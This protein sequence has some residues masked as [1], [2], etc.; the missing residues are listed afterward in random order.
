MPA[1]RSSKSSTLSPSSQLP[2]PLMSSI[3]RSLSEQAPPVPSHPPPL[4]LTED[5]NDKMRAGLLSKVMDHIILLMDDWFVGVRQKTIVV[6]CPHCVLNAPPTAR[7][8]RSCS[9]ILDLLPHK[10]KVE[11]EERE[12]VEEAREG[13]SQSEVENRSELL[14]SFSEIGR[15][16]KVSYKWKLIYS[17]HIITLLHYCLTL[18]SLF[19]PPPFPPPS[20]SLPPSSLSH[21][22]PCPPL[23][24]ILFPL[25]LSTTSSSLSS[26]IPLSHNLPLLLLFLPSSIPQHPQA[27]LPVRDADTRHYKYAFRY[28]DCVVTARTLNTMFCPAHGEIFLQ[29]MA[30]DTVCMSLYMCL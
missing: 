30:P 8:E 22:F 28:N 26:L 23:F 10:E 18:H 29:Y 24:P 13:T 11:R 4:V 27:T 1:T 5:K 12:K 9:D 21:L 14:R 2:V 15:S 17:V 7:M 16:N 6:P 25:L 3:Q 20:P 19:D